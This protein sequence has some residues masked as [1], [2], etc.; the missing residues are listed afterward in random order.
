MLLDKSPPLF[1]RLTHDDALRAL[2]HRA[3]QR[4]DARR[5]GTDNQHRVVGRN[6]TYARRPESRGKHIANKQSLLVG[7]AVGNAVQA[8][9]RQRHTHIFR[10]SAVDTASE[11]PSAMRRSAVVDIAVS[12]VEALTAEGFHIDGHTVA[13][14]HAFHVGAYFF[15]HADHLMADS[16]ARHRSRHT[17][18]LYMQVA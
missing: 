10:L 7:H 3:D 5:S 13:Y 9:R 4:A 17:P 18:V 8:L 12:A 15:H 1:R 6:L 2:Q 16:D 14:L 11:S